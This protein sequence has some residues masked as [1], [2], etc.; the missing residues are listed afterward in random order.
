MFRVI[1]GVVL[2]LFFSGE[3][4][5][6]DH[7]PHFQP[8]QAVSG[9]QLEMEADLTGKVNVDAPTGV[10]GHWVGVLK[11]INYGTQNVEAFIVQ[12]GF[13]LTIVT[14]TSLVYGKKFYGQITTDCSILTYDQKTGEDWSTHYGNCT[15]TS[16]KIYDYVN[17]LTA[18]DSLVLYRTS[19]AE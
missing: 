4:L 8:H 17:N 19:P 1:C 10:A 18:L 3:I 14:S 16:L 13:N 5:A 15:S 11:L 2:I 12:D 7:E 6:Q 9:D